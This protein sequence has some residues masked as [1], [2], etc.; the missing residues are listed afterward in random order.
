MKNKPKNNAP[1]PQDG[2]A[3]SP[4]LEMAGPSRVDP[5]QAA[6]LFCA[7]FGSLIFDQGYELW[8]LIDRLGLKAPTRR[9]LG[10]A[11]AALPGFD[12]DTTSGQLIMS[13]VNHGA[14]LVIATPNGPRC[15]NIATEKTPN[16][17]RVVE[18]Q[19]IDAQAPE[20]VPAA[21][22]SF[23]FSDQSSLA[24][25]K[26][27]PGEH[28]CEFDAKR[29]ALREVTVV[30]EEE[31]R[32]FDAE[33]VEQYDMLSWLESDHYDVQWKAEPKDWRESDVINPD[34]IPMES[35]LTRRMDRRIPHYTTE[36][37]MLRPT[38]EFLLGQ[39]GKHQ[40]NPPL[41]EA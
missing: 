31:N 11:I 2:L 34:Q 33:K 36:D 37:F 7:E 17:C 26:V 39:A 14:A 6:V 24:A 35:D 4:T 1:L 29:Q 8:S 23:P 10:R 12:P 38:K 32:L 9:E 20:G 18:V 19:L 5:T 13:M 16:G 15:I 21:R 28:A 30:L 27:S 3:S 22:R 40:K 25:A 41:H